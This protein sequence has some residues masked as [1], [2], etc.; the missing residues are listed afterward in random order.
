MI[1]IAR[2]LKAVG[3]QGELKLE[4]LTHDLTRFESLRSVRVGVDEDRLVSRSIE[5]VRVVGGFVY[6]RFQGIQ[7]PDQANMLRGHYLYVEEEQAVRPPHGAY[8]IH[9]IIG[10]TV[11]T[12]DGRVIGRIRDVLVFPANDVWVVE[13]GEEEVL[14]PA[15]KDVIR[16]VDIQGGRVVIHAMEGLFE[17]AD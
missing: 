3:I 14:L 12:T 1:A 13:C 2:I 9:D 8:F 10:L 6:L 15:I 4:P 7:D 16:Q 5:E 17:D 11:V